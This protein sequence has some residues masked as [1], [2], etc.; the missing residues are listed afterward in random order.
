LFLP[1]GFLGHQL[2]AGGVQT[3]KAMKQRILFIWFFCLLLAPCG[4][5][6]SGALDQAEILGRLAQGYWPSYV[7]HLVKT[8]GVRFSSSAD[9]VER[10]KLAGGD[11]ILVERLFASY[12]SEQP[13]W[14]SHTESSY[15]HLAKCAELIHTGAIETAEK[16]C[17]ASIDENPKSAW[18]LTATAKILELESSRQDSA[19]TN[20]K[21]R[22]EC[23][24]LLRRA[25]ALAPN[26][27]SIHQKL[28]SGLPPVDAMGQL[29]LA[30]ALDT[31]SLEVT[32][33]NESEYQSS[34]FSARMSDDSP[35]APASSS[36]L[37]NINPELQRRMQIDP[38]FAKNHMALAFEYFQIRNLERAESELREAIR[39][40]PDN[41]VLRYSLAE[42][43]LSRKNQE[44]CLAELREGVRIV[45]FGGKPHMVLAGALEQFGRTPE[46]IKEL[47]SFLGGNPAAVEPSGALIE[48][49]LEHKDRKSA[50]AELRRSLKATS[51]T[52]SN[53]AE[54]VEARY[55]DEGRLANLLRE[56]GEF[57]ASAEQYVYLLRFKP[58]DAGLHNDYGNVLLSEK[59]LDDAIGEYNES[60]R[61]DPEQA[62]PHH[63]IALCFALKKDMETAVT[64]FQQALDL[65]PEDARSLV[66]LGAALR[67]K[68]DLNGAKDLFQQAIEKNPN[69]PSAHA[70]LGYVLMRFK[71]ESGAISELKRALELKADTAEAENNLA[72]LLA[73]AEDQKL[74]NPEQS[75]ALARGAV[76]DAAQPNAAYLDTLAEALLLNGQAG[77]ALTTEKQALELDPQNPEMQSRL[78]HFREVAQGP[79]LQAASK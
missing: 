73:T 44:A 16:E 30:S 72:W 77:E 62:T 22:E 12:I 41:P 3:L 27:A 20:K 65:N 68:G 4:F 17:R 28:A 48:L 39:L 54:F 7:A 79:A 38:D 6:Q 15:D 14:T 19:E 71:D 8:R 45:P 26:V 11:G 35:Q 53:E 59:H 33:E 36:E 13:H 70:Q 76:K 51:L 24:E 60:L 58:D 66:F 69:D 18:P 75:L 29:Q 63:N 55:Q 31:E 74:R 49:Y 64:E 46:A 42:Y 10:V 2:V 47:Q 25:L 52:F 56:N 43:Y 32:E 5:A 67:M 40:E 78:A 37:T 21:K 50:I 57:A 9:F 1:N 61:L 34:L 23:T